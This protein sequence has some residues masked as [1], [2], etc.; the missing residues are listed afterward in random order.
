MKNILNGKKENQNSSDII[1][2]RIMQISSH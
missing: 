1:E 2:K